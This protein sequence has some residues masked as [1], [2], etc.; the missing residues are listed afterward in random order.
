[1]GGAQGTFFNS[2][3]FFPLTHSQ[4][5]A[6]ASPQAASASLSNRAN[7]S[8]PSHSRTSTCLLSP[9]WLGL[10]T[11]EVVLKSKPQANPTPEVPSYPR[12]K[13]MGH[14]VPRQVQIALHQLA[15]KDISS[16][17]PLLLLSCPTLQAVSTLLY[18]LPCHLPELSPVLGFRWGPHPGVPLSFFSV[19]LHTY[20]EGPETGHWYLLCTGCSLPSLQD[21]SAHITQ[22]YQFS[23]A[24]CL[25][26]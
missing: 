8:H 6:I 26:H 14:H 11:A 12:W 25:L 15:P 9:P 24:A 5:H 21:C 1:V 23:L 17:I 2:S 19:L 3:S 7:S 18:M 20:L 16:L 10:V 4:A 13:L 22:Y